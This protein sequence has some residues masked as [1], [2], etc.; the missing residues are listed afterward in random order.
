MKRQNDKYFVKTK[1][2]FFLFR[3]YYEPVCVCI[4]RNT[5]Y[6]KCENKLS[7]YIHSETFG[8]HKKQT[9]VCVCAC[10]CVFLCVYVYSVI[11]RNT[12]NVLAQIARTQKFIVS[13]SVHRDTTIR[14]LFMKYRVV[15][16]L[17]KSSPLFA[18][19]TVTQ[20]NYTI[21]SA[22]FTAMIQK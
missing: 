1:T 14:H 15:Q 16:L 3:Y 11:I 22:R 5:Q 19:F 8:V 12:G 17:P 20:L 2:I 9:I 7:Y 10:V 6:W 18:A 21:S 4:S 13:V